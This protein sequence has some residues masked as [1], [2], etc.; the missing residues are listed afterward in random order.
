L[1]ACPHK[2]IACPGF[3]WRHGHVSYTRKPGGIVN[4]NMLIERLDKVGNQDLF[5][6]R[7]LCFQYARLGAKISSW[8]FAIRQTA[9]GSVRYRFEK[10]CTNEALHGRKNCGECQ[11]ETSTLHKYYSNTANLLQVKWIQESELDVSRHS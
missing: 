11:C 10:S 2:G 9:N 8:T 6:V 5:D 4:H 7:K 3:R 1:N